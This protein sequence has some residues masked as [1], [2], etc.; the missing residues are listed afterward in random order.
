VYKKDPDN[1]ENIKNYYLTKDW[2]M[3]NLEA[4]SKGYIYLTK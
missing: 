4:L 2:F 3:A 1:P